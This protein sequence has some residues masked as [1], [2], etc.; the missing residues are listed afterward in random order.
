MIETEN[1]L[2]LISPSSVL[3]RA[4]KNWNSKSNLERINSS[5]KY[6]H[7]FVNHNL[8]SNDWKN[9]FNE[10]S[11]SQRNILLKGELI[12][13]YD[14]LSNNDKSLIKRSLGLKTFA[15]KW[16]KLTSRDKRILLNHVLN[17]QEEKKLL[18]RC[19]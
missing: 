14:S 11:K 10:L 19:P 3:V 5:R 6:G 8:I 17:G 1:G 18:N 15:S 7:I 13:T 4:E 12:R 2:V 9:D 16:F